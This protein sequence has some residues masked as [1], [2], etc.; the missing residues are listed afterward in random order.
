MGSITHE[1]SNRWWYHF[2]IWPNRLL[3]WLQTLK[4]HAQCYET[5]M[6]HNAVKEKPPA[7]PFNSCVSSYFTDIQSIWEIKCKYLSKVILSDNENRWTEIIWFCH[8]FEKRQTPLEEF[9][10]LLN[11][12]WYQVYV[13]GRGRNPFFVELIWGFLEFLKRQTPKSVPFNDCY[14]PFSI[15][16]G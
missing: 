1:L 12:N 9:S 5:R 15:E 10:Y 11:L 7:K 4:W 8:S 3:L 6:V 14:L 16:K 2:V 13:G